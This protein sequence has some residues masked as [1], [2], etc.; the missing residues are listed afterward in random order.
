ML[1]LSTLIKLSIMRLSV[2]V[3]LVCVFLLSLQACQPPQSAPPQAEPIAQPKDNSIVTPA[4]YTWPAG[5]TFSLLSWN[6][7]HFVDPYDNPYIKHPREDKPDEQ[8]PRR[9]NLLVK[10]LRKADADLVLLQE[11][12][13]ASYLQQLAQDSLADMGY[14]YFAAAPSPTWY[15]NVVLM[16]RFPLGVLESYGLATTALP[17]WVNE[18]GQPETQN[19]LNTRMWTITVYPAADYQFSLTGVHLKAGRGPRNEAMRKGQIA[20][21]QA[22]FRE[23]LEANRQ[24][25]I[26]MAGD[27]NA[28]PEGPELALLL[29]RKFLPSPML[30]PFDASVL[31]HPA[32]TPTRRLDYML[33]NSNMGPELVPGSVEVPMFFSADSM[34]MLADHLPVMGHF[35]R[36]EQEVK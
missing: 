29:D 7:E 8:M 27:F 26:L 3:L 18:A 14:Q 21:L 30:D 31:T 10:A 12:E 16:S 4:G 20:L 23:Q 17:D 28:L 36:S 13:S 33:Y 25:N 11:F 24:S 2:L 15:M 9:V 34:R 19:H 35:Y 1:N 32:D 6:V 5:E 22:R